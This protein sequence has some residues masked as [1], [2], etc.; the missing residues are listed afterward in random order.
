MAT[1]GFKDQRGQE[2]E[3]FLY[4]AYG[5]NLLTERIHLQNPSATFLCVARLQVSAPP[6]LRPCTQSTDRGPG[7]QLF[8]IRV[9]LIFRIWLLPSWASPAGPLGSVLDSY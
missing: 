9:G 8:Q 7:A 4:F 5:S 2:E 6:L 3:N 1:S